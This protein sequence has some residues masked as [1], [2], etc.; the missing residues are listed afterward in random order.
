V[1]IENTCNQMY[2]YQVGP[3]G[4][5]LEFKGDGDLHETKFDAMVQRLTYEIFD[6]NVNGVS[7][8]GSA[9]VTDLH[10]CKYRFSVYPTSA[11]EDQ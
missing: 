9:N 11:F 10:S 6:T 3:D 5:S 2:T 4:T 7:A 1:V 8:H